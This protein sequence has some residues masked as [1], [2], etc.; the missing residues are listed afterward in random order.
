MLEF[1]NKHGNAI[2]FTVLKGL[3]ENISLISGKINL[4]RERQT[5]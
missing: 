2:L 5:V 4:S 1:G 3:K